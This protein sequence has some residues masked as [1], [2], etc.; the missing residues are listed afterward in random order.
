[1]ALLDL[2]VSFIIKTIVC[3]QKTS[4]RPKSQMRDV[5]FIDK[6]TKRIKSRNKPR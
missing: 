1:M 4:S 5:I 6:H 3:P 2:S